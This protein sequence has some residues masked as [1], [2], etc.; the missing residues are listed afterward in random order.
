MTAIDAA[1]R[2]AIPETAGLYE[3]LSSALREAGVADE[4]VEIV[5]LK[6]HVYR[7]RVGENGVASS[8]VLKSYDPHGPRGVA[9]L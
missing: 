9:R 7:A 6:K 1:L 4:P 5:R 8:F 3:A 2:S